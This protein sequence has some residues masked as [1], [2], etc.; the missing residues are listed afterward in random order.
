MVS[1]LLG[2]SACRPV[3]EKGVYAIYFKADVAALMEQNAG[4]RKRLREV[5]CENT[6]LSKRLDDAEWRMR[7]L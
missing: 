1:G 6:E 2:R 3:M 7:Q 4:L 5:V